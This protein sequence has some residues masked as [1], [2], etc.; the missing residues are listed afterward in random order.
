MIPRILIVDDEAPV[1]AHFKAFLTP[2]LRCEIVEMRDG[3]EAMDALEHEEFH[4][5]LL[6]QNMPGIDG[7]SI[8]EYLRQNAP[9]TI[10][11]MITGLGG[12]ALSHKV[13]SLGGIY[14]AKPVSLK[15]LLLVIE[16]ELERRGGFDYRPMDSA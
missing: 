5:I 7:F 10:V 6:D 4:V 2:R 16:R 14:M 1:R 13:E 15:A 9:A 11:I 3:K 12:A 8:L